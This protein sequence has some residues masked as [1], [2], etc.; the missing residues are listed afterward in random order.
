M[1]KDRLYEPVDDEIVYH[2]CRPD[3]FLEIV[4]SGTIWHSA[5]TVLNDTTE[6]EWGY[7]IFIEV[8]EGLREECG[9][10]FID[11]IQAIVKISQT[12]SVAMISSYSLNGD[13][14]SQWRAYADGG[15]GFAIGFSTRDMDMP[16]KPLKVLY[17]RVAQVTELTANIRRL[18][19]H[20]RSTG[21]KYN[22]DFL[23][24]WYTFGL[25]LCAYKNPAFSEEM[26][27][28]R[29]HVSMALGEVTRVVIPIG[30]IDRQSVRRSP[31]VQVDFRV[32]NG[33]LVPYVVLD[34]TDDGK[35][36]PLREVVLG[37]KNANLE[38]N[39]GILLSSMG[40]N[41]VTVKRSQAP[42]R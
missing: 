15:R 20:E 37:P 34:Y 13:V 31:P 30:A 2:Y 19:Q 12:N 32:S 18:F 25:D 16:A 24:H 14:L 28:R 17:D 1:I 11:H 21:F 9:A 38:T 33:V 23:A 35:K 26:E 6:R 36:E 40:L 27:I 42:Y 5:Y 29:V 4:R 7:K 3:A 10:D 8:T 39:V 22:D 41:N